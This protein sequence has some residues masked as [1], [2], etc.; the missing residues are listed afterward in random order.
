MNIFKRIT[1]GHILILIGILHT[2]F[3]IS[4]DGFQIQFTEFAKVYFFNI[5]SGLDQ[6]P[7]MV[8]KTDFETFATFW[9]FYFGIIMFP[10]GFAINYIEKVNKHLP[11]LF[12]ISYLM[13]VLIGCYMVPNSGITIF[14]L[15][16]ALYMIIKPLF[17]RQP[18]TT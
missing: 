9:F 4:A 17:K 16:H 7:A 5:S 6:L 14:M 15:P 1:N 12:T 18:T 13:L 10:L 2:H 8:G 3:A 11:I